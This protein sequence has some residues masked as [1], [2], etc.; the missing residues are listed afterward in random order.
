[1]NECIL[2]NVKN[3]GFDRGIFKCLK[4][5]ENSNN[6]TY[7]WIKV[8]ATVRILSINTVTWFK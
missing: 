3:H 5:I 1:M 6:Y 8:Y 7:M 4:K 2:I